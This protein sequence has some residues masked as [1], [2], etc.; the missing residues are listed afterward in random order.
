M[1]IF[2]F[3]CVL[4]ILLMPFSVFA[5]EEGCALKLRKAQDQY[6]LGNI[7]KIPELLKSCLDNGFTRDEKLQAYKLLINAFIFDDNSEQ[8][9]FFMLE[10]LKKFPEYKLAATDPSE[11]VNLLDQ[12][13]NNPRS[14]IGFILGGNMTNVRIIQPYSVSNK[15]DADAKYTSSGL[16][17]QAGLMFN[18][19]LST[20]FEISLEPMYIQNAFEYESRP[21]SFAYLKYSENQTRIDFPV[22]VVYTFAHSSFTPYARLGFKTSYLVSGKSDSK[23]SYEN[24]GSTPFADVTGSQIEVFDNRKLNNYW[25]V[26]GGGLRYKIPGAYVFLDLRYNLGLLN[27]VNTNSRSDGND[28]NTWLYFYRQDDFFL[29]DITVSV[30]MAK[31]IYRPKRKKPK[32]K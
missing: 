29:D 22:S 25:A 8:A 32:T 28:D 12:F 5:Q 7:E 2:K 15:K 16:G 20:R 24:T 17:F 13:D 27:Q 10:F 31:T 19:N 3:I 21:F 4:I 9:E 26:I 11:F 14:S 23:R 1:K 6:N 18:V 30:G